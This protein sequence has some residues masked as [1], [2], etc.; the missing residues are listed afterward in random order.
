MSILLSALVTDAQVYSDMVGSPF[1]TSAQWMTFANAGQEELWTIVATTFADTFYK[2]NSFTVTSN[3]NTITLPTDFR[4]I[5]GLD[6]NPGLSSVRPIRRYNFADR[7]SATGGSF[8]SPI[9]GNDPRYRVV[10]RSTLVLEPPLQSNGN[11]M[12]Y[13]VNGP[14]AFTAPTDPMMPELESYKEY[15]SQ[16]MARKALLKEE[17]DISGVDERIAQMRADITTAVETDT[18][19]QDSIADVEPAVYGSNWPYAR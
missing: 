7:D 8:I 4:M 14:T 5:K 11:Y 13:Y 15:I 12:L 18:A 10:S 19:E 16:V 9:I 2:T 1:I 3:A 17:S 6:I